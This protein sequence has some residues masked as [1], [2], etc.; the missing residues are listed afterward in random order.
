MIS[1]SSTGCPLFLLG[2]FSLGDRP[3]FD[4]LPGDLFGE[5][6]LESGL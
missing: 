1:S 5:E 6:S 4:F 3:V 2:D